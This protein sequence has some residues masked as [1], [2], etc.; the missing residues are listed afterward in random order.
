MQYRETASGGTFV[1]LSD[2]DVE[3][4]LEVEPEKL[5]ESEKDWDSENEVESETLRD[6]EDERDSEKDFEKER[7][8]FELFWF[9]K[10]M[11]IVKHA[12]L[13]SL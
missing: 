3:N 13:L 12:G 9:S 7:E 8:N 6:V 1:S 2:S 4:V 11:Q 5:G 10:P